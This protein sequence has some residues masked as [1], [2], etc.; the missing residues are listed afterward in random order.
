MKISEQ[1]EKLDLLDEVLEII[2]DAVDE[3]E[4]MGFVLAFQCLTHSTNS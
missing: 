1:L 2:S 3:F 4:I